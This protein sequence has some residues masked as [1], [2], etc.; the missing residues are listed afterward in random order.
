MIINS[1]SHGIILILAKFYQVFAMYLAYV[2]TSFILKSFWYTHIIFKPY[3][4]DT[5]TKSIL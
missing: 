3:V 5:I 1:V 4:V 2:L